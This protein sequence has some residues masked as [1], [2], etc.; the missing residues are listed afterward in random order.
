MTEYTRPDGTLGETLQ[1][2]ESLAPDAMRVHI[3]DVADIKIEIAPGATYEDSAGN[4]Q[5]A[6]PVV[7]TAATS[8]VHP[9]G[10]R[11]ASVPVMADAVT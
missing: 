1:V 5:R 4:L 10:V 7:I 8:Y 9:T 11:L 2:V 6:V 3:V